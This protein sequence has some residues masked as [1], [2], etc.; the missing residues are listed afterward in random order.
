MSA[1]GS[2]AEKLLMQSIADNPRNIQ[3]YCDL[4]RAYEDVGEPGK[5]EATLLRA[6]E[7]GPL[8]PQPWRQLGRLYSKLQNLRGSVDAFER[9]CSLDPRDVASRIGYGWASDGGQ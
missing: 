9:A 3:A 6:I 7:V 4:A 8:T 1:A 2:S 5:A